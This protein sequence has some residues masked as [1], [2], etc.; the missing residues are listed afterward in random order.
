MHHLAH[1]PVHSFSCKHGLL[2]PASRTF[3]PSDFAN[4][5]RSSIL[6]ILFHTPVTRFISHVKF[7]TVSNLHPPTTGPLLIATM[8]LM[9]KLPSPFMPK[10]DRRVFVLGIILFIFVTTF[11]IA[12][13]SQHVS[14]YIGKVHDIPSEKPSNVQELHP[15]SVK[16]LQN[17]TLGVWRSC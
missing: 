4:I 1:H 2:F 11:F 15:E 10:I 17:A 9:E 5:E 7:S 8:D 13:K 16:Q 14:Q 3:Y 6:P 12:N